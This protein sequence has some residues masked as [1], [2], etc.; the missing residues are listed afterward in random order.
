VVTT[1]TKP[2]TGT[3][4]MQERWRNEKVSDH[5]TVSGVCVR[6]SFGRLAQGDHV[7]SSGN[8]NRGAVP[9]STECSTKRRFRLAAK[10][11]RNAGNDCAMTLADKAVRA[12]WPGCKVKAGKVQRRV[13]ER[14][15]G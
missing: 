15:T 8:S 3:V 10:L 14:L 11:Y 4:T 7:G 9:M 13:A 1:V 6:G 12:W 2:V 5:F